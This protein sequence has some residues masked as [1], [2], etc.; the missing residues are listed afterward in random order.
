M[1][2]Q[3]STDQLEF[4]SSDRSASFPFH[5]APEHSGLFAADHSALSGTIGSGGFL[6]GEGDDDD[7]DRP[8]LEELGIDFR[9]ILNTSRRAVVP[10]FSASI[11]VFAEADLAGP[12][13]FVLLLGVFLLMA[14]KVHFGYIYG[15][16]VVGC[17]GMFVVLNL[18]SERD[19]SFDKVVSI[20]GYCLFPNVVLALIGVFVSLRAGIGF[21]ISIAAVLWSTFAATRSLESTFSLKQQRYLVAYPVF[22]LYASFSL[23]TVF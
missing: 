23:I 2:P 7:D 22:L 17:G 9:R 10:G 11:E 21:A 6:S 18:M 19:L 5:A 16:G 12:L 3:S 14:S 20:L 13:V 1:L 15:L 8:L 4:L